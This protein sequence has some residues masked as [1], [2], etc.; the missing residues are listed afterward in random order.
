MR[1]PYTPAPAYS[2]AAVHTSTAKKNS[3][4]EGDYVNSRTIY[5]STPFHTLHT[6]KTFEA[7]K[8]SMPIN[9]QKNR[10]ASNVVNT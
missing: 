8:I 2:K 6:R 4:L 7:E 9:I 10:L 3:M 5:K 1:Y